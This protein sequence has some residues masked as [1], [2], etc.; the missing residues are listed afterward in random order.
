ME[1]PVGARMKGIGWKWYSLRSRLMLLVA[2]ALCP[3]AAMTIYSGW[4]DRML[5]VR[6]AQDNLQRLT[7]LAAANEAQ[8]LE[9]ARQILVDLSSVP[10]LVAGQ[11]P[12]Q[13]LLAAVLKKNPGYANFGLIQPNGDVNCS[14]VPSAAPVNLADREHFQRA[15]LERRFVASRYVFG[16][17]IRQHTINLT[18]PVIDASNTVVGV[19]FAALDLRALDRFAADVKLP[20]G[21]LLLTMDAGGTLIS[22]RPDP[23]KWFGSAVSPDMRAA[24]LRDPEGASPP[25]ILKGP[26][27]VERLH[28]FARVGGR[29]V[30]DYRLT[31]GVP[32]AGITAEAQRDQRRDLL[33]LLA[34]SVLALLAAW[35]FGDILIVRR[36][37]RLVGTADRIASGSLGTR[38]GMAYG[39]EEI[40]QLARALDEMALA[41]QHKEAEYLRAESGLRAADQRKDEF[42][43]M[44]AHELRNPL[45]PIATG[46]QLLKVGQA[47][48]ATVAR[49]ADI[50]AR[51]AAHMTRLVDDLLDV[52][53]VTRGLIT[54]SREPLD[55]R[56]VVAEALEQAGPLID[57]RGHRV[58]VQMPD[59]AALLLGDRK[60]L[61]QVVGNLLNNAAKYT[62]EGRAIA[63]RVETGAHELQL[64]VAD[65]GVGMTA[66]L[67]RRVFELFAQADRSPDRSQGGLGLGLALVRMLVELHGGTVQ[68]LSPGPDQGSSFVVRLPRGPGPALPGLVDASMTSGAPE[69]SPPARLRFLVVDDN[70]DAADTLAELLRG[71]GHTVTLAYHPQQALD[72]VRA[73]PAGAAPQVCLLDIGLPGFDGHELA[74]RLR[75]T[76]SC[77]CAVIVAVTGYGRSADRGAAMAAGFDHYFI[78][79][80]DPAVL[81]A[82]ADDIA[83]AL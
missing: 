34:T 54:L 22:R 25:A 13:A 59:G 51:Q 38:T 83:A 48:P 31:I 19:V 35:F 68:A 39:D 75:A 64:T 50:I 6:V 57:S 67:L 18:Y 61:V 21:S 16:R 14:A 71:A 10:D 46:A 49:T 77:A 33:G 30:S 55:F 26:D 5:A 45:A 2:L 4:Q 44:L 29:D 72:L 27:G 43:A 53:R 28:A 70:V 69:A 9:R 82:L 74:R 47:T 76:P 79:P 58:D 36:V 24:M 73:Q 60:R 63:V 7:R 8:S 41:L 62:P 12:C 66:E 1:E 56:D 65:N 15:L 37:R 52:S 40:S 11:R 80:I 78:K 17:V 81:L 42:L 32:S 23:D 20:P 3:T